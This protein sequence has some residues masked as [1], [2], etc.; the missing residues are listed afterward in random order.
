MDTGCAVTWTKRHCATADHGKEAIGISGIINPLCL[1]FSNVDTVKQTTSTV[2]HQGRLLTATT[3]SRA[4]LRHHASS[5][6]VPS[7]CLI[8]VLNIFFSGC[9]GC[10]EMCGTNAIRT[11]LSPDF[12]VDRRMV[13]EDS[14]KKNKYYDTED[15]PRCFK[16]PGLSRNNRALRERFNL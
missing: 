10:W 16:V 9:G 5:I 8:L 4:Q 3:L 15:A 7:A 11:P 13:Q 14:M 12:G 2:P 1:Y 6:R